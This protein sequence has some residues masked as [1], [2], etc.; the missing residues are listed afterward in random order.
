MFT[1]D[2]ISLSA[3]GPAHSA[4]YVANLASRHKT[5]PARWWRHIQ[6]SLYV[7][8]LQMA[9]DAYPKLEQRRNTRNKDN[10][11]VIKDGLLMRSRLNETMLLRSCVRKFQPDLRTSKNL[12]LLHTIRVIAINLSATLNKPAFIFISIRNF[13][14]YV[15]FCNVCC[16][17][18][19]IQSKNL[20]F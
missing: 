4:G 3:S 17:L 9:A 14:Y 13:T 1:A 20:P 18:A 10:Y 15:M 19:I 6:V 5:W 2:L 8:Q 12:K 11:S 16:M 7:A